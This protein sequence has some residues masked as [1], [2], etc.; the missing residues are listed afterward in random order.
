MK[1]TPVTI[2]I[3]SWNNHQYLSSALNSLLRNQGTV[4]LMRIIVVNNGDPRSCDW[5]QHKQITVLQAGTNLGWEGGLALGL[6]HTTSEFVCFLNDDTYIPPCSRLWLNHLINHFTDPKVAAVG[7]SSNVVTGY[8]NIFVDTPLSVFQAKFLIGFCVVVRRSAL[9]EIGGIDLELESGDDFDWS[10]RLR[11]KGYKLLVDREVFVYHH[12]FKSGIRKQGDV[13]TPGGWNSYEMQQ[14]TNTNLIKKHGLKKWWEVIKSTS[15]PPEGK[16]LIELESDSEG[17]LI[18]SLITKDDKTILDLGCG[19]RKTL[20]RA[21]GVDM[22]AKGEQISTLDDGLVSQA[23]VVADVTKL[24]FEPEYADVIIAR[25]ILEHALDLV[26]TL[27]HWINKLKVGGRLIIAVP[28]QDWHST[29]QM[30]IEHVHAFSPES[31]THLLQLF[32]L[33]ILGIHDPKNYISFVVEA[34]RV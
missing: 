25:H 32:G 5:I 22:I 2:L 3:P 9:D 26:T 16:G 21:I 34:R 28:N 4:G 30:N 10:I 23:D 27:A 33:E 13:M 29:I 15:I 11:D 8:Q 19:P 17:T 14:K 1:D 6:Q 18:R 12:G 24:P 20:E 7:P 31:L